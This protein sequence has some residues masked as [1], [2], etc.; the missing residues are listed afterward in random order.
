MVVSVFVGLRVGQDLDPLFRQGFFEGL[1]N[2]RI[3][4]RQDVRQHLD[5]R[6]FG[7]K[8]VVE[9]GKLDPNRAGADDDHAL[10]LG[11]EN[12]RLATADDGLAVEWKARQRT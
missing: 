12:H 6:H 3:L 4:D 10:R 7:A 9:I 5:Q 11:I 2:L 8:G 1:R